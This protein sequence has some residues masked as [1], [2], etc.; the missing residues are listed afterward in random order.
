MTAGEFRRLAL[1][2]PE[3]VEATHMA[4]PDFRVGG[5]I[6]A[7]LGYPSGEWGFVKL[8]PEQQR[9]FMQAEP[10]VFVPAKG[11]WGLRGGTTVRLGAA[12]KAMVRKALLAAWRNTAP[13]QLARELDSL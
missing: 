12:P 6:F 2:L 9:I 1:N 5:K 13:K 11:V 4:H 3:T 8:R 7:T 10:E